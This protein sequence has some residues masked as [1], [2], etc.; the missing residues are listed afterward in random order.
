[1]MV[2]KR[3]WILFIL[4]CAV[5][6]PLIAYSKKDDF[7]VLKGPYLG[8]KPPGK[9]PEALAPSIIFNENADH[10]N[11]AFSMILGYSSA[12]G[13]VTMIGQNQSIC[14]RREMHREE[15]T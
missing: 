9:L 7:P 13:P 2:S 12:I 10:G 14:S 3:R 15:V 8:Q 6:M 1:M 4:T 11:I 5:I